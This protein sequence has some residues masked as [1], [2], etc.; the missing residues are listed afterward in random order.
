M[1]K[2]G[3]SATEAPSTP[4]LPAVLPKDPFRGFPE[5][6]LV[7]P[8]AGALQLIAA[9]DKAEAEEYAIKYSQQSGNECA[10]YKIA[11]VAAV[12]KRHVA[13]FSDSADA[14]ATD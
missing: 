9:K 2:T 4:N 1:E 10:I 8:V 3:Q 14:S 12:R 13:Y 5:W 7:V 6:G 11:R